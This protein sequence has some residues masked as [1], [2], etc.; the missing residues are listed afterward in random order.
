MLEK[1]Y[2]SGYFAAYFIQKARQAGLGVRQS[3]LVR[4]LF[5]ISILMRFQEVVAL[6]KRH[7]A[8]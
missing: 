5:I 6:K 1:K 2:F 7:T 8:S 4:I 3:A